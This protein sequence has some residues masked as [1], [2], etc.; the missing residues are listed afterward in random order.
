MALDPAIEA[1]RGD[2]NPRARDAVNKIAGIL[3]TLGDAGGLKFE[4]HNPD[5][6]FQSLVQNN[7]KLA[8]Q[9]AEV[10][11]TLRPQE[12]TLVATVVDRTLQTYANSGFVLTQSLQ[13]SVAAKVGRVVQTLDPTKDY[14]Q[15]YGV[16]TMLMQA[17]QQNNAQLLQQALGGLQP[18]HA[19]TVRNMAMELRKPLQHLETQIAA[20]P[21]FMSEQ[22]PGRY[23]VE[24]LT[25]DGVKEVDGAES[26]AHAEQISKELAKQGNREFRIYDKYQRY[27]EYAGDIPVSFAEKYAQLETAAFQQS[28]TN[29]RGLYGEAIANRLAQD[30]NPA[31]KVQEAVASATV[32]KYSMHRNLVGGRQRLDYLKVMDTYVQGLARNAANRKT[33]DMVAL[34]QNDQRMQALPEFSAMTETQLAHVLR[35][36]SEMLEKVRTMAS[37]YF[38][39][40]NVANAVVEPAQAL[41]AVVPQMVRQGDSVHAAYGRLL[42]AMSKTAKWLVQPKEYLR[43]AASGELN[44]AQQP[45]EVQ[46]AYYF[47]KFQD[48]N[49]TLSPYDDTTIAGDHEIT[50]RARE[51][52]GM[53]GKVAL[54]KLAVNGLYQLATKFMGI[55]SLASHWNAR[56]TFM[57]GLDQAFSQGLKG[58]QAFDYAK[59]LVYSTNFSGGKANNPGI[60]AQTS[61]NPL[62][63]N[64]V[65]MASILQTFGLGM[66]TQLGV[67]GSEAIGRTKG[68]TAIERVQ[69]RKAFGLMLTTQTALAGALGLPFAAASL[70]V[71]EKTFGIEANAA[72]RQGLAALGG[73]DEELGAMISDTA[74]NGLANQLFGL[75]IA[76]KTGLSSLLGSSP[77]NGFNLADLAGP[78]P[79]I[80]QNVFASLQD[81]VHGDWGQVAHDLIPYGFKNTVQLMDTYN[82]RG[83]LALEDKQQNLI[84]KPTQ[85]QSVLYAIGFKPKMLR[86]Y[87][88][89]SQLLTTSDRLA[90]QSRDRDLD[91]LARGLLQG[92]AQQVRDYVSKIAADSPLVDPRTVLNSIIDKALDMTSQRDLL[93]SGGLQNAEARRTLAATFPGNSVP[94][95]SEVQRLAEKQRMLQTLGFPFGTQMAGS[96]EYLQAALTDQFVSRG[97]T[98][99]EAIRQAQ[100]LS[101]AKQ[102][103][104][105]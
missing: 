17:L 34:M 90:A 95:R 61:G 37:A 82:K 47:R 83:E 80:V 7:P 87:Q 5:L 102:Y 97:Y 56:T 52:V 58:E 88:Q 92:Q 64:V 19:E 11:K 50:L 20:R 29:I 3:Q 4:N 86:Q 33:R 46:E 9:V 85:L 72:L 75:D 78:A 89:A 40:G 41:T 65:G 60:V 1:I 16:G 59:M 73:D 45:R 27:G 70:A 2:K 74:L 55:Y 26:Q 79:S 62:T 81:G 28:L 71:L 18:A 25:S 77:Y 96:G 30:F 68:L 21:Y 67:L 91:A 93:A 63:R 57:A 43:L 38:L 103:M 54:G 32:Q 12:R 104:N 69:A 99:S 10:Y 13:E 31:Q 6:P 35:P 94:R 100:L 66:T 42:K 24:S 23:I 53:D 98:R 15:A 14:E 101:G 76:G 105:Y 36:G 39:A 22:R 8:E 48:E 44:I 84:M 49:P 51:G